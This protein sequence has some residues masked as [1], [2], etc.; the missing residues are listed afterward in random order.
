MMSESNSSRDERPAND[1]DATEASA[2]ESG[3]RDSSYVPPSVIAEQQKQSE[4]LMLL[5]LRAMFFVLLVTI[6]VL[7]A[8]SQMK[9]EFSFETIA[10]LFIASTAVAVIVLILDAMTPRKR[11]SSVAGVFLGVCAGLIGALLV[12]ALINIIADAWDLRG[13][14]NPAEQYVD[15]VKIIVGIVLCYLAV[16]V[17]LTTKD[18]FRLVI[19]YVEFAKQVRGVRPMALDSSVLIDGRIDALGQT[20]FIDAPLIVPQFV[21]NEL[22]TLADSSDKLKRTRG[23][24]GLDMVGK[25]QS[26]PFLDVSIDDTEVSGRSVDAALLE[27]AEE[28]QLRI[29]TT[30][31]NLNKVAQIRGVEVLNIND[32]ANVLRPQAIPGESLQIEVVKRGEAPGQG[33][34]Y[35]PDGTMVVVEEGGEHVGRT[36]LLSVTNSLQTSAGKMIF[37][38]FEQVTSDMPSESVQHMA[39]AA[40]H[41]PRTPAAPNTPDA[42]SDTGAGSGPASGPR[43]RGAE[44][45]PSRRNPRR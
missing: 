10:G 33:V 27:F 42:P 36:I 24:R 16:S 45:Q 1:R 35:L 13:P 17:V 22:Q 3:R 30:D 7:V 26:N 21:V 44:Y 11:L 37:G 19:P 8:A 9:E 12:G 18:D 29:L 40:T 4:R 34:G 20:G 38:K 2:P 25:L 32:L 43:G 31:Y 14:N 23:R 6:T 5:V 41:Q 15:L 28:Q 39:K